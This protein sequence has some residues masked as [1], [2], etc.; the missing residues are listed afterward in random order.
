MRTTFCLRFD[1]VPKI[2][3]SYEIF[4]LV[5]Y[6]LSHSLM[7]SSLKPRVWPWPT[8]CVLAARALVLLHGSSGSSVPS[9]LAWVISTKLS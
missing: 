7:N 1:A 6:A 5:A 9:L 8:I 4:V 3:A 2:W